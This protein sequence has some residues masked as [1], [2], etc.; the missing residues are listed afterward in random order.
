MLGSQ[1]FDAKL[2]E[3]AK[4]EMRKECGKSCLSQFDNMLLW[5]EENA[6]GVLSGGSMGPFNLTNP[7]EATPGKLA[8]IALANKEFGKARN[9]SRTLELADAAVAEASPSVGGT[10]QVQL[11]SRSRIFGAGGRGITDTPCADVG[12]CAMLEKTGQLCNYMRLGLVTAYQAINMAAHVLVILGSLLCGGLY[13]AFFPIAILKTVTTFCDLPITIFMA[14]FTASANIWESTKGA[15]K[16]C[17]MHGFPLIG[18][19]R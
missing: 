7:D 14:G 16:T 4:G 10:N 12:T 3:V 2:I 1:F 13:I 5:L 17:R 9:L 18:S 8:W 11:Q 15:T 6:A 19:V